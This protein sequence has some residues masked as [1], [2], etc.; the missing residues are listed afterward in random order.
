METTAIATNKAADPLSEIR[1]R[2][3]S[4]S[5]L[6]PLSRFYLSSRSEPTDALWSLR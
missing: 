5:M 2:G 1:D 4:D 6:H 3:V